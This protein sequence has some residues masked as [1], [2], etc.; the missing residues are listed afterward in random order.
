MANIALTTLTR[1]KNILLLGGGDTQWNTLL[2]QFI[3]AVSRDGQILMDRHVKQEAMVEQQDVEPGQCIFY[4]TA[5]PILASP[6]LELR[7][8]SARDFPTSSIIDPTDYFLDKER[9]IVKVDGKYL[10]WGPGA[11]KLTYT[12]GMSDT[13]VN[14]AA[15]FPHIANAVDLQVA[16]LFKRREQMGITGYSIEGGSVSLSPIDW[17]PAV[18]AT[19]LS[20]RRMV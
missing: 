4:V 8:D 11:A 3:D 6:A 18:K 13:D 7:N 10:A 2:Q 19:L 20:E 9:G 15:A 17:L 5:Y 1:V 16:Y 14:F 12:G